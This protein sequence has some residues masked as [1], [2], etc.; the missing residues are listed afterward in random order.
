MENRELTP[1]DLKCYSNYEIA[2]VIAPLVIETTY[3]WS[4]VLPEIKA[5]QINTWHQLFFLIMLVLCADYIRRKHIINTD[6]RNRL[7]ELMQSNSGAGADFLNKAMA[8]GDPQTASGAK[9]LHRQ[10]LRRLK[11]MEEK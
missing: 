9:N 6:I 10:W 5:R 3:G 1:E 8:S 2:K 7:W 11:K 4:V